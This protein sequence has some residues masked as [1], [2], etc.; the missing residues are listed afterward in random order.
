[1]HKE[2]RA[3]T[4]FVVEPCHFF[5]LRLLSSRTCGSLTHPFKPDDRPVG[6]F[7]GENRT[8]PITGDQTRLSAPSLFASQQQTPRA[9]IFKEAPA[10][11]GAH[12]SKQVIKKIKKRSIRFFF[13]TE[14]YIMPFNSLLLFFISF[15][16]TAIFFYTGI[17]NR[18][19]WKSD[20]TPV[21]VAYTEFWSLVTVL[22]CLNHLFMIKQ[23]WSEFVWIY[24]LICTE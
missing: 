21:S 24:T 6:V 16:S 4:A 19:F 8:Q 17:T 3:R 23:A 11:Y 10:Y 18:C 7:C 13:Q 15:P 20:L 14:F 1:M 12:L 9:Q 22:M 2:Q 5:P